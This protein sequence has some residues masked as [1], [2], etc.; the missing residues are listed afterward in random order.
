M[1]ISDDGLI[2]VFTKSKTNQDHQSLCTAIPK[3]YFLN[4]IDFCRDILDW[5]KMMRMRHESDCLEGKNKYLFVS[6]RAVK[7]DDGSVVHRLKPSGSPVS[8]DCI[9]SQLRDLVKLLRESGVQVPSNV[10]LHSF[11]VGA[12]NHLGE[13]GVDMH[14]IQK[15]ARNKELRSTA[16]YAGTC[17]SNMLAGAA[18]M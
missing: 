17:S 10:G 7:M 13:Q 18:L 5:Q 14:V 9:H 11:H 2:V 15:Q 3:G 16:N 8:Y 4:E 6:F 12:I 1:K